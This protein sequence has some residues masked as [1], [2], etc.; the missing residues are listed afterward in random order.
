[1]DVLQRTQGRG[2]IPLGQGRSLGCDCPKVPSIPASVGL[3]VY[4]D[5]A[6]LLMSQGCV[7]AQRARDIE[8]A[9]SR[10]RVQANIRLQNAGLFDT[11]SSIRIPITPK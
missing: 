5:S 9:D 3:R 11:H 2:I 7:T 1:M 6:I 8:V 4:V 10:E